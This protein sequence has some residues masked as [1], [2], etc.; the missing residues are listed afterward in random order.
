MKMKK[1]TT[2][3]QNNKNP[4]LSTKGILFFYSLNNDFYLAQNLVFTY[5]E[6]PKRDDEEALK[7]HRVERTEKPLNQNF[8]GMHRKNVNSNDGRPKN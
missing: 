7:T 3:M 1:Y 5:K 6:V 8:M 2:N 4:S